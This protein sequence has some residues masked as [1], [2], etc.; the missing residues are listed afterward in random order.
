MDEVGMRKQLGINTLTGEADKTCSGRILCDIA[1][2]LRE[3]FREFFGL[4]SVEM[5]GGWNNSEH[6]SLMLTH[7]VILPF[8]VWCARRRGFWAIHINP[9]PSPVYYVFTKDEGYVEKYRESELK[10]YI[11][12]P[13]VG[14]T[15]NVHQF[16]GRLT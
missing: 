9:S 5:P 1:P 16:S 12:A 7:E 4:T 6:L 2:E 11:L 14:A 3:E 13:I 10:C 15:R 8:V